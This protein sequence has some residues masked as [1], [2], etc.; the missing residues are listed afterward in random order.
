[1]GWFDD[2]VNLA[3]NGYFAHGRSEYAEALA[4]YEKAIGLGDVPDW[5]FWGAA[6][7]A[8]LTGQED[9]ALKYLNTAIEHGFDNLE[10]IL[11]SKYLVS[12]H[13][14]EGWCEIIKCLE[15]QNKAE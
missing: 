9:K 10:D 12:L 13:E 14:T 11:G 6:C 7:D 4:F 5:A 8:A 15:A 3:S 1:M 2:S